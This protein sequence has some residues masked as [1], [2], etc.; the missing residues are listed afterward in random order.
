ML[1][2]DVHGLLLGVRFKVYGLG[3]RVLVLIGEAIY[4]KKVHA[5]LL[6]GSE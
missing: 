5:P 6:T 2:L 4:Q 1:Y 3:F